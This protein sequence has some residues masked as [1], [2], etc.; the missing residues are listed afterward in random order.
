MKTILAVT[1]HIRACP[2]SLLHGAPSTSAQAPV[3]LSG[4]EAVPIDSP[5]AT[6]I[7]LPSRRLRLP[8]CPRLAKKR[9]ANGGKTSSPDL[10]EHR[11]GS[12]SVKG[13]SRS[14]QAMGR[15]GGTR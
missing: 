15:R 4:S 12:P 14:S 7:L 8:P 10:S 3:A 6:W 5:V 2:T 11:E 9:P 1:N 13:R